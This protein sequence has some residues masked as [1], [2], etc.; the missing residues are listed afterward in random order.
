MTA[1]TSLSDD[2]ISKFVP[3]LR[4]F[5][6][7]IG[8]HVKKFEIGDAIY[9][10]ILQDICLAHARKHTQVLFEPTTSAI[11]KKLVDLPCS[12]NC[13][14]TVANY[15]RNFATSL[16]HSPIIGRVSYD[17]T[18]QAIMSFVLPKTLVYQ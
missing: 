15:I 13:A 5:L 18:E 1:T 8:E 4:I 10:S 6:W 9:M 7:L 14:N 16:A 11:Q 17:Y 2:E 3:D 12:F